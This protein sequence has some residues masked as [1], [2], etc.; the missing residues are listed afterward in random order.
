MLRH[1]G[2]LQSRTSAESGTDDATVSYADITQMRCKVET[3][4][5]IQAINNRGSNRT[6]THRIEFRRVPDLSRGNFILILNG[7][8]SGWRFKIDD[9]AMQRLGRRMFLT[10]YAIGTNDAFSQPTT[11]SLPDIFS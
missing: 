7:P 9:N 10:A 4:N 1:W 11:P 6:P 8:Y 2:V 3:L 5:G